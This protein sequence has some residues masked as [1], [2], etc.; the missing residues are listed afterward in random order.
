MS[1]GEILRSMGDTAGK[2]LESGRDTVRNLVE[3]IM[4]ARQPAMQ[5]IPVRVD[6]APRQ[7][8]QMDMR[9]PM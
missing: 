6:E 7:T 5:P 3:Q 9:P 8:R 1:A 4:E 2:L